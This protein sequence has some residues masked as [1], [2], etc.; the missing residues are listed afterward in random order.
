MA[1]SLKYYN[2]IETCAPKAMHAPGL[3]MA[4][5]NGTCA[6]GETFPEV[7]RIPAGTPIEV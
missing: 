7:Q 4:F 2:R 3:F 1:L 5:L 6:A